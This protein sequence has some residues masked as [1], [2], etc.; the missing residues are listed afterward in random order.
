LVELPELPVEPLAEVELP[1]VPVEVEPVPPFEPVD[2]AAAEE[3]VG[4][5]A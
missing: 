5:Q 3:L 1:V 4:M 2:E